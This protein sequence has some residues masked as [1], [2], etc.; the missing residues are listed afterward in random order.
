ME[1]EH[2]VLETSLTPGNVSHRGNPVT[3]SIPNRKWVLGG[4]EGRDEREGMFICTGL[5]FCGR[6]KTR[7]IWAISH[8]ILKNSPAS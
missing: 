4:G 3:Q 7:H 5:L 1:K 6:P 2:S 8:S